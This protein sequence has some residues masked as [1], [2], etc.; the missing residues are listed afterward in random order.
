M[1]LIQ[2]SVRLVTILYIALAFTS[3]TS[4][5]RNVSE[6]S[7]ITSY[8]ESTKLNFVLLDSIA[9]VPAILTDDVEN[10][11]DKV[12]ALE[13]S[14]LLKDSSEVI[15]RKVLLGQYKKALAEE[16]SDFTIEDKEIIQKV[17]DQ[18]IDQL[19][20]AKSFYDEPIK[21]IKI[22]ADLYGEGVFFT[23]ENCIFIPENELVKD[24]DA[25]LN[26][27]FLHEIF[28][29]YSRYNPTFKKDMYGLIG[30]EPL[31]KKIKIPPKLAE[32]LLYN[33]D[34]LELGNAI[35]LTAENKEPI[36][37][38]SAIYSNSKK[39]SNNKPEYFSYLQFDLFR[40]AERDDH[41][42]LFIGENIGPEIHEDYYL[43][44][45]DQIKDN[46]QYIIHPDEIMA[47][48]FML[49]V[50]D[51]STPMDENTFT[52]EGRALINQVQM[53][54]FDENK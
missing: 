27:V 34:G 33:P 12:Q 29:I 50:Q 49:A 46:T 47:D 8:A 21:L 14:I 1:N 23:R 44:F 13:M 39:F 17:E 18:I 6:N 30:V 7:T 22:K 54:L 38:V 48:N 9:A 51:K 28:H 2:L 5:K 52:P 31:T 24:N 36:K 15:D 32:R 16:V 41:Y 43:S 10:Y 19:A 4:C 3:F 26:Q 11:F 37:A 35:T 20:N 25:I 53:I 45:F 42:A 40:I